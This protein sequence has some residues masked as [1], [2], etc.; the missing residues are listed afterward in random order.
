MKLKVSGLMSETILDL[1]Q[2]KK[3][4]MNHI[5]WTSIL[6]LGF[7]SHARLAYYR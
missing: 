3:D 7:N 2:N 6:R 1:K 4:V 5:K